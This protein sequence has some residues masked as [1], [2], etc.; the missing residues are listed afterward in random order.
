MRASTSTQAPRDRA[1]PSPRRR[2]LRLLPLVSLVSLVLLV[3]HGSAEAQ[4]T[5]RSN[6]KRLRYDTRIDLAVTST[7]GLWLAASEILKA[8]L[9]PAKCRWCYRAADGSDAL[10]PYDGYVRKTLIW[11]NTGAADLSSSIIAFVLLPL[12]GLGTTAIAANHDDAMHGYPVDALSI[13]EATILAADLN[14]IVKFA[15]ARERPFVHFLPRAPTGIRAL[16]DSP[17]DDNLSFFS[18]HTN[19]AFAMA[20]SSGTTASLRNYRLAP[21]VWG[22]GLT[23]A[24]AVAYLRIAADKHYLS[25]V[26]TA[27]VVGSLVGVGVPLLF[28]SA[29]PS[30]AAPSG[31]GG[32]GP[33]PAAMQT[34]FGYGG[35]F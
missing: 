15:F 7:G 9:V 33:A 28:H 31:T 29:K 21:M 18:G 24:F 19:L 27:V 6:V 25:D 30:D 22:V 35:A 1:A 16:T 4:E 11:Q 13:L 32:P 8:Q 17:S 14:Q 3:G 26:L 10:N 20:T 23:A 34:P 12:A 5:P 2:L